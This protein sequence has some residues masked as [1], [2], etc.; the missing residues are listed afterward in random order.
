MLWLVSIALAAVLGVVVHFASRKLT[1]DEK[2]LVFVD[3]FVGQAASSVFMVQFGMIGKEYGPII[4]GALVFIHFLARNVYFAYSNRLYDNP[5]A[6][7]GAYYSEGRKISA[8]PFTIAGVLATQI[9]A[10]LA[11]QAFAKFVWSFGDEAHIEAIGAECASALSTEY[12]CQH[13]AFFEAL[14]VFVLVTVGL[15]TSQTKVQVVA[16]SVAATA[17]VTFMSHVTGQFMNASI[18]TAYTY[19]CAG[20]PDE[21]K[22]FMVYW[23]APMVGMAFAWEMWLGIDKAKKLIKGKQ[24]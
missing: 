17:L 20:H 22:F 6:F 16:L 9:G 23:I 14:G 7:V 1:S 18:A 24:E 3:E 19:R 2:V 15:V 11:G 12:S 10:L 21:W 4:L 13:A 5:V 8:S